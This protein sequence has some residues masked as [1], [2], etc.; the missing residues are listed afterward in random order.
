[1]KIL[2]T[3]FAKQVVLITR[4][5]VL[6]PLPQLLLLG[7]TR[8]TSPTL[9]LGTCGQCHKTFFQHNLSSYRHNF[10]QN[11]RQYA[12]SSVNYAKKSF[13]KLPAGEMLK[14]EK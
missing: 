6:S 3:C 4:S 10:N 8:D 5:T 9:R 11:L 13:K 7:A 12:V 1:M 2:F 14:Q